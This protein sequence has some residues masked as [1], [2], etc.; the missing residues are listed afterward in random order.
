VFGLHILAMANKPLHMQNVA[1]EIGSVAE[2]W[3]D[4]AP[5]KAGSKIVF[6]QSTETGVGLFLFDCSTGSRKKLYE[7][8]AI[9]FEEER[10]QLRF[11][12]W[13]WSPDDRQFIYS[14]G[15]N[16]KLN[17]LVICDGNSG[18]ATATLTLESAMSEGVW[19]SPSAFA[20][21][22]GRQ[23]LFKIEQAKDQQWSEPAAFRQHT[24]KKA[25]HKI[26]GLIALTQDTVAWQEGK[27]IWAWQFDSPEPKII[28]E[29][30][31]NT[32]LDFSLDAS[33]KQLLLHFR[34]RDC[35]SFAS[36]SS[37]PCLGPKDF[38]PALQPEHHPDGTGMNRKTRT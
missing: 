32:L 11:L 25:S 27:A 16:G 9:H 2:F 17:Q 5:N 6:E 21:A 13:G 1:T 12:I 29:T 34:E 18:Q 33:G 31:T 8:N 38:L 37:R 23:N 4:P 22:D 26:K 20:Y 3:G 24:T 15:P 14:R 35:E 36:W 10:Q 28:W 19:L 30:K 7:Q